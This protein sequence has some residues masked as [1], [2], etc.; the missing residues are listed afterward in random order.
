MNTNKKRNYLPDF[1]SLSQDA[2]VIVLWRVLACMQIQV[3]YDGVVFE[4]LRKSSVRYSSVSRYFRFLAKFANND[5]WGY[6]P[7]NSSRA[8][9]FR[10]FI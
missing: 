2:R 5:N 6:F 3:V 4:S 9:L 8:M 10:T 1:V 7:W